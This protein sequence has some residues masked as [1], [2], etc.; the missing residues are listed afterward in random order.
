LTHFIPVFPLR[1]VVYPGEALNLHIFEPRYRQ[2]IRECLEER[3]PFGLP[4]VIEKN[5]RHL[6]TQME[7]TELAREYP[8]GRMDIRTRG[9]SVFRILHGVEEVPDKLYSGAIVT[10]PKNALET[11]DSRVAHNITSEVRRLY[12]LLNVSE[13]FP[14][15][16]ELCSYDLAH[17]VGLSFEQEYELL[18]IFTELQRLEYLRR[19]LSSIIPVIQELEAMKE[20]IQRNGHFR[21]LS[22]GGEG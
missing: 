10:Y 16:K 4:V 21:N 5:L 19:H 14:G 18:G 20:R 2:L 9:V 12:E 15:D 17:L 7:I 8:D 13:R 3:K 1:I 6:G 22:L 11:G